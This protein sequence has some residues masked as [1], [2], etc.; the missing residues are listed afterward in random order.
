M[1]NIA[2]SD[3]SESDSTENDFLLEQYVLEPEE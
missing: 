2:F 1:L 3:E